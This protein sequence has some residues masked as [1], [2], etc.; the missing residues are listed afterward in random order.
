MT[1]CLNC[2]GHPTTGIFLD[3]GQAFD[4]VWFDGLLF[5][6]TSMGLNRKLD[7]LAI[8]SIREH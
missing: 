4:Q 3:A 6:L 2:K 7:G 8:F 5:K 1:I